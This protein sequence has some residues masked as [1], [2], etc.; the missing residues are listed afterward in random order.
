MSHLLSEI[1]GNT[2]V[3]TINF[4]TSVSYRINDMLSLGVGLDLIY[5]EGNLDRYYN[6]MPL[7][8][9]DADGWGIG[10]IVGATLELNEN[11]RFGLSYRYSPNVDVSGHI[12]TLTPLPG[13]T[14]SFAS[15]LFDELEVPLADIFQLAGFHQ[16]TE[17]FAVHYTAQY[18]RWGNFDQI[19]AKDGVSSI[20]GTGTVI[21]NNVNAPLKQYQW[22]NSWLMSVGGTYDINE[23]FTVRAGYM[24]DNGVVDEISSI[25][26]PDSDRQWFTAGLSYHINQHQTIDFG[27]AFVKGEEVELVENSAVVGPVNAITKSEAMYYSV[28]Y[29][30]QF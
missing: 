6:Q 26:I 22:K 4:N 8:D 27:M 23:Q 24:F 5:G 3:T 15:T 17:N 18:T 29:S 20:Y 7:V 2:E 13:Q 1:G 11:N 25:S 21:A 30:Y 9:V 19:T 16:L 28:Q 14:N 10:G 12:A